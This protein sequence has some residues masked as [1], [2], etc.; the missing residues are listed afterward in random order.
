MCRTI[1]VKRSTNCDGRSKGCNERGRWFCLIIQ[2]LFPSVMEV[3]RAIGIWRLGDGRLARSYRS[4]M[5]TK[6][7]CL[8][9]LS[10]S[11]VF[12]TS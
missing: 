5:D 3:R 12:L 11:M 4:I 8:L 1:L 6:T 10:L 7:I 9:T 2:G